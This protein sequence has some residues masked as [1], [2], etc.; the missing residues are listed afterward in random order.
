MVE[1]C[2]LIAPNASQCPWRNSRETVAGPSAARRFSIVGSPHSSG[3]QAHVEIS[4][5]S[6]CLVAWWLQRL[7]DLAKA[8]WQRPAVR[9][10]R[11]LSGRHVP[12]GPDPD[13]EWTRH[14]HR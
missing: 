8:A 13:S 11:A 6:I 7:H 4:E 2:G 5:P 1:S 12:I 14:R 9:A 3:E 10:A